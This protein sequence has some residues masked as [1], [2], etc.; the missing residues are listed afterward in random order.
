MKI[1]NKEY[2]IV[3]KTFGD[4]HKEYHA[5]QLVL[6]LFLFKIWKD[7]IYDILEYGYGM[8]IMKYRFHTYDECLEYLTN[9][10]KEK[11]EAK[12]KAKIIN[13]NITY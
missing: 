6:N 2:R 9:N 1:F 3:E 7:Y 11:E 10:I 8:L 13:T 5:Q 12:Q 4:G